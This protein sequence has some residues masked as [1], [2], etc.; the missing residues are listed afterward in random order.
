M[1]FTSIHVS[2]QA[3]CLY[4]W[5]E[6][7]VQYYSYNSLHCSFKQLQSSHYVIILT[8]IRTTKES[9]MLLKIQDYELVI[10]M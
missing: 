5:M 6:T 2:L 8:D 1:V 9:T 4:R 7:N 10:V 3:T